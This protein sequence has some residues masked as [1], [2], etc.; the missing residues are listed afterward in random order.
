MIRITQSLKIIAALITICVSPNV[1]AQQSIDEPRLDPIFGRP[2]PADDRARNPEPDEIENDD[3]FDDD[4]KWSPLRGFVG[5]LTFMT[6]ETTNLSFG[7]GPV[8]KPDYFGSNDYELE[9]DP[10]AYAKFRNFVFFD[11]DG[12]DFA[13]FGFSRF[14]FGPSIRIVGDRSDDEN[15]ALNGLGDVGTT[16]EAGAFAAANF[17]DRMSLRFKVRHGVETGHRGLIV[18]AST[19]VLLAK[20]GRFSTSITG[21]AAWIGDDY[22]DAYFSVTPEQSANSGLPVYDAK[23]G[24][25]D[26]GG[27]VNSYINIRD[28]WSLNPYV[29]YRYILDNIANTPIIDQFGDRHQ[30][31]VGFH[32]IREFQFNMK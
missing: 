15:P 10:Q 6:P 11:D 31:T 23:R 8:Y 12:A 1:F 17:F 26:L 9:P 4:R 25:R 28:N 32:L 14:S 21:Q 3:A 20:W 13:L 19:T 22:A 24:L 29:S 7:V 16:F 2:T 18:D 5:V 30:F 27:S